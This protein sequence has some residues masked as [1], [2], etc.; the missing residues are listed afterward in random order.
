VTGKEFIRRVRALGKIKSLDVRVDKKNAAREVTRRFITGIAKPLCVTPEMN[1]KP[2]H[3]M[4]NQLG[5]G[6]HEF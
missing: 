1:S 5:I 4:L 6:K 3:A 2:E